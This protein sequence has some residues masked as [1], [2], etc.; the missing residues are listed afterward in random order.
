MASSFLTTTFFSSSDSATSSSDYDFYY[1]FWVNPFSVGR[2]LIRAAL[3]IMQDE[4]G[5]LLDPDVLFRPT[6]SPYMQTPS[7]EGL[8]DSPTPGLLR[9]LLWRFLLGLPVV[10]A[11]SV[12]HMLLSLPL[13]G[14]VQWLARFR[15]GRNRRSS[16]ARDTAA[17]VI[18]VLLVIGALRLGFS[19]CRSRHRSLLN[20][21]AYSRALYKVYQLTES[22]TKRLLLRAE[23]IIL[24]V[25][26]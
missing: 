24:E 5:G 13:L 4:S 16:G 12:V 3:R 26:A 18:V 7:S 22:L 6:K 2:D 8:Q 21:D 15:G 19:T 1:P 14:H 20:H 25:N 9:R 11:G 17:V 10:G 23:D